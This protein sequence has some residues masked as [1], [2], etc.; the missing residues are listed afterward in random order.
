M[1]TK[2][3]KK[4]F[5]AI[6]PI[7]SQ[8]KGLEANKFEISLNGQHKSKR[9]LS[10]DLITVQ[11]DKIISIFKLLPQKTHRKNIGTQPQNTVW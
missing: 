5:E 3:H 6:L 9:C 4:N 11:V 10:F 1:E 2:F 8:H 7:F